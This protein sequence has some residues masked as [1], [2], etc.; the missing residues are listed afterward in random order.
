MTSGCFKEDIEQDNYFQPFKS[1]VIVITTPP[2]ECDYLTTQDA[3]HDNTKPP[4]KRNMNDEQDFSI[5]SVNELSP[6][7]SLQFQNQDQQ[8]HTTPVSLVAYRSDLVQH[9]T[10]SALQMAN[11]DIKMDTLPKAYKTYLD[12]IRN[13]CHVYLPNSL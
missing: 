4:R 6:I 11:P 2:V 5:M 7:E 1:P 13:S 8:E 10:K 3:I 12:N 9:Y